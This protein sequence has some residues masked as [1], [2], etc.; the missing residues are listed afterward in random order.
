MRYWLIVSLLTVF[1]VTIPAFAGAI[2]PTETVQLF[3]GKTL[4]N[5]YTWMAGTGRE[6]ANRVFSVAEAI[7]GAP[8]IRVSGQGYGAFITEKEYKNYHLTVEFRWGLLTWGNRK[9]KARD[10]GILVHCQGP[11]GNTGKDF[12]GPWMQSI[13]TQIIEGGV[14]DI[15]LVAGWDADGN[16]LKPVATSTV[17]KD[18]DDETVY[19]PDGETVTMDSGRINWSGRDPD[20]DGSLGYTGKD[21]VEGHGAEWTTL[22]V[23]CDGD[24]ITNIV[25][26]QVVSKLWDTSLTSGKI[27]FQ[28]EGAEL[29]FRKVELKPV[30]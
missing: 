10:S 8:A 3:D 27:I 30:K 15:I 5:F 18:R 11:D 17:V 7:D 19:S 23:I 20:W 16:R 21:D 2:E 25:N 12:K 28:T 9:D 13:E 24:V 4:D 6:D 1:M 14:A 26:G 22:E 29:Y